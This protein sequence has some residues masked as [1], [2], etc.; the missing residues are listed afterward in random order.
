[1]SGV[2]SRRPGRFARGPA[3]DGVAARRAARGARSTCSTRIGIDTAGAPRRL[4]LADLRGGEDITLVTMRPSDVPDL[5]RG[6][7]RRRRHHRQGRPARAVRPRLLRASRPRLR[8]AAAWSWPA[9][10]GDER[11]A[12]HERAASARCRIA[13]K[14]PRIAERYFEDT[15]RAGRGDRGQGLGRAGAAV[16]ASPTAIVDLVDTGRTLEENGLEVREEIANCT[17]RLIANRVA[18]KLRAREIDDLAARLREA[19]A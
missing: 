13:T 11:L 3:E 15:G 6:R 9:A 7:R 18:H 14:Y 19:T 5:R 1:M 4:A 17:A 10:D 8:R 16:R 12:E 2:A